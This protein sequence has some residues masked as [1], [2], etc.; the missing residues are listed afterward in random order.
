MGWGL[1]YPASWGKSQVQAVE[2]AD[3]EEIVLVVTCLS[4]ERVVEQDN[5]PVH[6]VSLLMPSISTDVQIS[7][8]PLARV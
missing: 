6:M 2:I 3:R 8:I 1:I 4:V 5:C 7:E